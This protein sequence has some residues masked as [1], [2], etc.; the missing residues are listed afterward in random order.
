MQEHSEGL[1]KENGKKYLSKS[2]LKKEAV[3]KAEE[4]MAAISMEFSN[5]YWEEDAEE[6]W[7]G[8]QVN[9]CKNWVDKVHWT[10]PPRMGLEPKRMG[11]EIVTMSSAKAVSERL[12]YPIVDYPESKLIRC[13]PLE[14]Q[15]R[16]K[17]EMKR[18]AVQ[19]FSLHV[20]LLAIQQWM[21]NNC[22]NKAE[23]IKDG[24][25]TFTDIFDEKL[26]ELYSNRR[27]LKKLREEFI[28]AFDMIS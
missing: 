7:T 14:I 26:D 28:E 22:D 13:F 20:R 27:E 11:F 18:D 23:L 10:S 25:W 5:K 17:I 3:K 24:K 6:E 9:A 4:T 12:L 2:K 19:I 16:A 15:P 1:L 8:E 21:I